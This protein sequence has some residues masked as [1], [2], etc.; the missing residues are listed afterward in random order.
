VPS[1]E[2]TM[3]E[4]AVRALAQ[5]EAALEALRARTGTLLTASSLVASFLGG[6]GIARHGLSAWIMLALASFAGVVVRSV[7]VLLPQRGLNFSLDVGAVSSVLTSRTDDQNAIFQALGLWLADLRAR[8]EPV[9]DRIARAAQQ[10]GLA[11]ICEIVLLGVG[12][13]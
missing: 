5:Q 6:Q 8:N 11:L 3:H 12:L 10:V 2:Q 7:Y 1:L 13:A 4:T 9:I